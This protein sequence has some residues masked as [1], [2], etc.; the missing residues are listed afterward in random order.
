MVY[1]PAFFSAKSLC[2][3]QVLRSAQAA[4]AR[5]NSLSMSRSD[6]SS[7]QRS[8]VSATESSPRLGLPLPNCQTQSHK[9]TKYT[10]RPFLP[11]ALNESVLPGGILT[12]WC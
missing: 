10:M 1:H 4:L 6:W 3:L 9:F 8:S 7:V 5:L 2:T 11:A 12:S